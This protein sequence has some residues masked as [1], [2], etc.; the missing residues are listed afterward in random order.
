MTSSWKRLALVG[1]LGIV[2]A[3]GVIGL[4]VR[5]GQSQSGNEAQLRAATHQRAALT[6]ALMDSV[7]SA[8]SGS[9]SSGSPATHG[10]PATAP[11]TAVFGP[12][13]RLLGSPRPLPHRLRAMITGQPAIAQALRDGRAHLSGVLPG[14]PQGSPDVLYVSPAGNGGRRRARVIMLP[15]ADLTPGLDRYL[16]DV[17][18]LAP[19]ANAAHAYLVD[20][21]GVVL[22][23]SAAAARAGQTLADRSLLAAVSG[24][25]PAGSYGRTVYATVARL[26]TAPWRVV[27]TVP[28]SVLYGPRGA[29]WKL[30]FLLL[31]GFATAAII[32]LFLVVRLLAQSAELGRANRTLARGNRDLQLATEA[33]SR[34]VA[35]LSHELRNPLG[36]V[37]GYAELMHAGRLGPLADRQLEHLGVIRASAEH[38]LEL[39]DD[40]LDLARIEAGHIRLQ[41]SPLDAAEVASACVTSLSRLAETR[42][43]AVDLDAPRAGLLM[44]DPTRLRQVILNY[45]SNAIKF[46]QPDGRVTVSVRRQEGGLLVEVTDT[47][48]GIEPAD[49]E[50][51]FDE[52]FQV[53]GA[54]HA[55]TGLGLA[56]TKRIVEAQGG[57]VALRSRRGAGST[58]SAWL[59]AAD[60]P[61]IV[62]PGGHPQRHSG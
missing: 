43:V 9:V 19:H 62:T 12:G 17:A 26:A 22:G 58:F 47:G 54:E 24:V 7:L 23:A 41:P 2:I 56:V 29:A 38:I 14:G 4:A 44:L 55:G 40:L 32:C 61:A 11:F 16:A 15:L 35:N 42:K 6:A 48:P 5:L 28:F 45:V 1:V 30:S 37:I 36:A 13:R 31:A 20:G 33:K 27:Y 3:A 59:P 46:T 8:R 39:I 18:H 51:V 50:Q 53:P 25:W 10:P 49:Q 52:F 57:T 34:F 60:G 21:R